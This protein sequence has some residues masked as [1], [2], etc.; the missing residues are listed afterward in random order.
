MANDRT[1]TLAEI[2][3]ISCLHNYWRRRKGCVERELITTVISQ[4]TPEF[5][6][7]LERMNE[8]SPDFD[9]WA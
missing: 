6:A 1:Y 4:T 8:F 2:E 3:A 7:M 5:C 9:R